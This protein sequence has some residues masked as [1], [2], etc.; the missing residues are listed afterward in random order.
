MKVGSTADLKADRWVDQKVGYSVDHWACC[1]VAKKGVSW[2]ARKADHWD[3]CSADC[4]V[5]HWVD[6]TAE[7]KADLSVVQTVDHSVEK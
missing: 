4:W 5:D 1:W 2:A 7:K 3:G 6:Q